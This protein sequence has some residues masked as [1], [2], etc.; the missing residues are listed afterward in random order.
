M[1]DTLDLYTLRFYKRLIES[2]KLQN[3]LLEDCVKNDAGKEKLEM[4]RRSLLEAADIFDGWISENQKA[5][6]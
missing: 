6:V 1:I 5:H 4:S 3:E 2:I